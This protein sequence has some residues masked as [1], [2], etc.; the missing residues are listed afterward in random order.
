MG[1]DVI[2]LILQNYHEEITKEIIGLRKK[3]CYLREKQIKYSFD[4][5]DF[6]KLG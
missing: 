2:D 5:N 1:L 4:K 6:S 3:D